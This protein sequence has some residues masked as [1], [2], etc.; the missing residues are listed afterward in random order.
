[1]HS[2]YITDAFWYMN[3]IYVIFLISSFMLVWE[4][5]D[6]LMYWNFF[7][8]DVMLSWFCLE[9]LLTSQTWIWIIQAWCIWDQAERRRCM[10]WIYTFIKHNVCSIKRAIQISTSEDIIWNITKVSSIANLQ[11]GLWICSIH[12]IGG[13]SLVH[14]GVLWTVFIIKPFGLM[15]V[16]LFTADHYVYRYLFIYCTCR[17][18]AIAYLFVTVSSEQQIVR[19][20]DGHYCQSHRIHNK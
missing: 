5:L 13:A 11:W 3:C 4:M 7:P 8:Y 9:K 20:S 6:L 2:A 19:Q 1:M 14:C 16:L 10:G 12:Q 15:E 17:S 18:L